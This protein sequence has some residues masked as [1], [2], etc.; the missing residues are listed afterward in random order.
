MRLI[1]CHIENF[2][3][4]CNYDLDFRNGVT[5]I[6]ERNGFGKTTFATFIKTMFYGLPI[7]GSNALIKNPR[8]KYK[9]WQ[10]GKFGGWLIFEA[11]AQEL[12]LANFENE[13]SDNPFMDAA[14]KS[15]VAQSD[16]TG[17]RILADGNVSPDQVF[18]FKVERYFGDTRKDDT[19]ELTDPASNEKS[20]I[21]SEDLG[22]EL[23]G[24][25]AA[26][27]DRSVY[28][29]Q[30]HDMDDDEG[31][32][33]QVRLSHL[34]RE[35][36]D[37]NNYDEAID[38][39]IE[40]RKT[41]K[42]YQGE[43]GSIYEA[44]KKI[45]EYEHQI[46]IVQEMQKKL[47]ADEKQKV[48][49]EADVKKLDLEIE[50]VRK[51]ISDISKA[52]TEKIIAG[53]YSQIKNNV[54]LLSKQYKR[55][56]EKY[57]KGFP[58]EEEIEKLG[59]NLELL[60]KQ[61]SVVDSSEMYYENKRYIEENQ[62]RFKDGVPSNE[63]FINLQGKC[64]ECINM[65]SELKQLRIQS[66][67]YMTEIS[68]LVNDPLSVDYIKSSVYEIIGQPKPV[69][70]QQK[71][72]FFSSLFSGS[73]NQK[74]PEEEEKERRNQV[75]ANTKAKELASD[76]I[77][78]IKGQVES[79][80]NEIEKIKEKIDQNQNEV[81]EFL[82]KYEKDQSSSES[83][84][85]IALSQLSSRLTI[86]QRECDIFTS[87]Q[88]MKSDWEINNSNKEEVR[89]KA[90]KEVA[91]LYKK[92]ELKDF[93]YG[94]ESYNNIKSGLADYN[95]IKR[96]YEDAKTNQSEFLRLNNTDDEKMTAMMERVKQFEEMNQKLLAEERQ[97]RELEAQKALEA[98][99]LEESQHQDSKKSKISSAV[100]IHLLDDDNDE[101]KPADEKESVIEDTSVN[102]IDAFM[103]K[104]AKLNEQKNIL[105]QNIS[106][107]NA[108]TS[109]V[110]EKINELPA[111]EK[112]L[113]AVKAKMKSD[114]ETCAD[115]DQ[116]IEQ[117][118]NAKEMINTGYLDKIRDSFSKYVKKFTNGSIG[119]VMI[120]TNLNVTISEQGQ[121]RDLG[122][123]S[124]GYEDIAMLCMRLALVDSL[125][126]EK[127]GLLILDDP[128]INLD[129]D[130]LKYAL[131]MLEQL[132]KEMQIIY[133]VCNSGRIRE[134]TPG[135]KMQH[136]GQPAQAQAGQ[137]QQQAQAGQAQQAAQ[138]PQQAGQ[139][140]QAQG[141]PQ[142][143][144]H[145]VN[146]QGMNQGYAAP[147]K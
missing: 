32:N 68:Q 74:S 37:E 98:K 105:L 51:H 61:S 83:S 145:P 119:Q 62:D 48:Q 4:L 121:M 59:E 116:T 120:D 124:A 107:I 34:V 79:I 44:E 95:N 94:L 97:K 134:T 60:N 111:I 71:S 126:S 46:G 86:L 52:Q 10:G 14:N 113:M 73:S 38:N 43:G 90:N 47:D 93:D 118:Q 104:Q 64:N 65:N 70:S 137:P 135:T 17:P 75:V 114:I 144:Q 143:I 33:L 81:V 123:F 58:N 57:P 23:F 13:S 21:F 91:E 133:L 115:I 122:H 129:D 35:T 87:A 9:P 138:Q 125:F 141:Q 29:P 103:N 42:L 16:G 8:L 80:K 15:N 109:S 20:E 76:H 40:K 56:N 89:A 82:K 28:M 117:M 69:V 108:V 127:R 49:M 88:K 139:Q 66:D 140:A 11:T 24:I 99:K 6:M 132:G 26:S 112:N 18:R 72:G 84:A 50:G 12:K 7:G 85:M 31:M 5:V 100:N 25:D 77:E 39:L 30:V 55:I 1:K 54:E 96:H 101:K 2:G 102:S 110:M 106:K 142:Q 41:F 3:H 36:F 128:F 45:K 78:T 27:F 131:N 63:D 67:E 19:F 136:P 22:L 130:N 92:Y 146:G 53:Q 147:M